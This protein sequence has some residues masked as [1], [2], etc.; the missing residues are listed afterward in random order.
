MLYTKK[1]LLSLFSSA[2]SHP[3]SVFAF[4]LLVRLILT[5]CWFGMCSCMMFSGFDFWLYNV[6]GVSLIFNFEKERIDC[7]FVDKGMQ[8]LIG[9]SSKLDFDLNLSRKIKFA[10][11]LALQS[12]FYLDYLKL[13]MHCK[14]S[15]KRRIS[16]S[17]SRLSFG[18]FSKIR[19]KIDLHSKFLT[20]N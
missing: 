4:F 1:A 11:V 8:F 19:L 17:K 7:V 10:S 16:I 3:F 5:E 18:Q 12:N 20:K 14:F 15:T 9:V 6:W 13:Q 2:N